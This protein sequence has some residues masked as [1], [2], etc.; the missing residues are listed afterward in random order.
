MRHGMCGREPGNE[1]LHVW[2]GAWERDMACV[3][4][5]LGTRLCMCGR[6][7]GDE[8]WHVWEGPWERDLACVGGSLGMRQT[9]HFIL[10]LL[11]MVVWAHLAENFM[12]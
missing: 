2:E 9:L 7:P 6:E 3:G 12:S 1:N 4:G 11:H 5:T 8:T 10:Y